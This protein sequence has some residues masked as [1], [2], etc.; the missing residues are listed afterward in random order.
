MSDSDS[1]YLAEPKRTLDDTLGSWAFSLAT[2]KRVCNSRSEAIAIAMEWFEYM[3]GERTENIPLYFVESVSVRYVS[4]ETITKE[5]STWYQVSI[6]MTA[7]RY[8]AEDIGDS[9]ECKKGIMRTVLVDSQESTMHAVVI[10]ATCSLDIHRR[11]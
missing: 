2:P 1:K 9:D 7:N 3:Y 6:N 4:N 8:G 11:N 5:Y 10:F